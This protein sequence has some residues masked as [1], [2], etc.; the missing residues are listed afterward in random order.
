[1]A[2]KILD[3][4]TDALVGFVIDRTN[5]KWGKGR[6]YEI[7]MLFLWLSTWMMF[8]TPVG[9][10][11]VGKCIWLFCTYSFAN[12]VSKTFLNGN[13]VVYLV[14]AFKTKV[15][16]VKVTAYGSFFTMGASIIFNFGFPMAM[17][18]LATSPAGWSKLLAL[19]GLP[20]TIVG[21]LRMLTIK[22]QY[23]NEDDTKVGKA[24]LKLQD[25][26]T[27]LKTNGYV[28]IISLAILIYSTITNMGVGIYYWQRIV[29]STALMGVTSVFTI[30]GLPLAFLLPRWH[31][32]YGLAK[33]S[34]A[35]FIVVMIGYLGIWFVGGNFIPL[36]VCI[37]LTSLGSVPFN[38]M[39]NIFIVEMS[40]YN[41]FIGKPRMEGTIGSVTGL[42][43]R[44][45]SALGGFI[46]GLLLSASHY[47]GAL[48][49]QP[50][51][52][53]MMI[54]LLFSLI[55][56]VC[57]IVVIL[58]FRAYKLDKKAPEI[59]A[60]LDAKRGNE[61]NLHEETAEAATA[62]TVSEAAEAVESLEDYKE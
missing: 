51:S 53:L 28:I 22:E 29:G 56:A 2:S 54:R 26:V 5:T 11:T 46:L 37:L 36:V 58:L 32:K 13:N 39:R 3:A 6:P 12:A 7:F 10:S 18:K 49:V 41:E 30:V 60:Y 61:M 21:V 40:D 16:Q 31:R 25:I 57:Y 35:G 17:A 47:D 27:L 8:S 4:V 38:M 44:I 48:D 42:M 55:P 9:F 43:D 20:L 14:R 33:M 15:Q 50:D 34:I 59:K 62:E 45:G 23:N 19:F 24:Q 1:M 52:A